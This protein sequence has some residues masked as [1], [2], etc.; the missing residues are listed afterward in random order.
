MIDYQEDWLIFLLFK[1][2]GSVAG[3][4]LQYA[5]PAACFAC[6]VVW[7]LKQYPNWCKDIGVSEFG[8][9]ML[10][11]TTTG[12]LSLLLGF[13][14]TRSMAR[15]WEGTGLLHQMRGEWFDSISCCITFTIATAK[16]RQHEVRQFRHT[17]V[18]LMSLCHGSALEEIAGDDV[19]PVELIDPL[20]LDNDTLRHLKS[21]K[22]DYKFNRVEVILHLVQTLI[23]NALSDG[24]IPIPPP[25]LS[26]V[27][28]TLSRGFVNLLNAKKIADTR[29]PF[30]YAQL[31]AQLLYFQLVLTPL[32]IASLTRHYFW[33]FLVTFIATFAFF[34]VNFVGVQLENP[35]GSDENDLPLHHFQDEMNKC[36][37]ML[38]HDRADLI[39]G[40]SASRSI[41]DFEAL[42]L[43]LDMDH[44]TTWTPSPAAN[45]TRSLGRSAVTESSNTDGRGTRSISNL[46]SAAFRGHDEK[47]LESKRHARQSVS[48]F[49]SYVDVSADDH[50]DND[51]VDG[52]KHDT[53]LVVAAPPPPPKQKKEQERAQAPLVSASSTPSEPKEAKL[54]TDLTRP[55]A[56]ALSD[57]NDMLPALNDLV[58]TQVHELSRSIRALAQF[59]DNLPEVL[60]LMVSR[61]DRSNGIFSAV[62]SSNSSSRE[63][64]LRNWTPD[65]PR[66][67]RLAPI[68]EVSQ[69][70]IRQTPCGASAPH[71]PRS[72][73][74]FS[75]SPRYPRRHAAEE[76]AVSTL[77]ETTT[78]HL[79]SNG[80]NT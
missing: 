58:E 73:S 21:C 70:S 24:L 42:H 2:R 59:S 48:N 54:A 36:L 19:E 28:Q 69:K 7:V 4:S 38:L 62:G 72:P 61:S 5:F 29:F 31:I 6:V 30:P 60:D 46:L 74:R 39:A 34:S 52:E 67:P 50:K 25:I 68:I 3:R 17:L 63:Q 27:Y 45:T 56:G 22:E 44:E 77:T 9:S 23:T 80:A 66:S 18:R 14:T 40:C 76:P 79:Q 32:M 1:R 71:T 78:H 55:L 41:Q 12:V 35:F 26:R 33:S 57:R 8:T 51:S 10:W 11:S 49:Q 53:S 65:T 20:G 16:T 15:F 47:D 13:R 75:T 64:F 37:M 43:S